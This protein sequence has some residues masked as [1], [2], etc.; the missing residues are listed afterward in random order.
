MAEVPDFDVGGTIHVIINNQIGFTTNPLHSL[1]M[2]Y[3]SELGKAITA[4]RCPKARRVGPTLDAIYNGN[5]YP[6][7]QTPH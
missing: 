4:F 5:R 6:L 7:H 1:S 2:P 3:S